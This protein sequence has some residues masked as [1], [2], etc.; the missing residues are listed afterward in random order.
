MACRC[1]FS[2]SSYEA[3]ANTI[4][5][6]V[7][8]FVMFHSKVSSQE[9]GPFVL[10]SFSCFIINLGGLHRHYRYNIYFENTFP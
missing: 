2:F 1:G 6:F 4:F 5:M 7:D 8:R 10:L 9:C 3:Y